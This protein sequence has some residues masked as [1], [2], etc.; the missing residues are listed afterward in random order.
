MDRVET[1]PHADYF[2][3]LK[4]FDEMEMQKMNEMI[5]GIYDDFLS[6]VSKGRG[7]SIAQV[8]SIAR[9]RVW[10]GTEAKR[11]GLV[12]ELG[13]LKEAI[14]YASEKAGMAQDAKV[15][16]LPKMEDPFTELLGGVAEAKQDIL[17]KEL[18]GEKYPAYKQLRQLIAQPGVY[19]RMPF[20]W[21]VK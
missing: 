6:R 16:T 19:A 4:P 17:L 10:T 13:G 14:K 15:K 1:H 8:D 5:I 2:S 9:G 3:V 20:V 7:M 12:D 21:E 11:I 18:A